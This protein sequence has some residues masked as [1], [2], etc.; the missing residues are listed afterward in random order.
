MGPAS[1]DWLGPVE[2]RTR[3]Y[4]Q[5]SDAAPRNRRAAAYSARTTEKR[6]LS[7]SEG[8]L[9][10]DGPPWRTSPL[11]RESWT[12]RN[13]ADSLEEQLHLRGY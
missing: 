8:V 9:P 3:A 10:G 6:A 4:E 12:N 7:H 11:E 13:D 5:E 2:K 1:R